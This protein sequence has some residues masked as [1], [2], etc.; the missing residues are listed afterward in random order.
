MRTSAIDAPNQ[1]LN[2]RIVVMGVSGCGK[3]TVGSLLAKRLGMRFIEGDQFHPSEN[4]RKMSAG[5]P[6]TDEDRHGWL[7]ELQSQLRAA[8]KAEEGVVLTCSALKRS[9]RELLRE[10]DSELLFIHLVGTREVIGARM[11]KRTGH[12]MPPMLLE[13]QLRDLEPPEPDE[14]AFSFSIDMPLEQ[15][16]NQVVKAVQS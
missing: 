3:S 11:H 8:R 5:I 1:S 13:S 9:Y 15:L 16:L 2:I 12:F 14:R 7:L 4:L 6:L 10:A